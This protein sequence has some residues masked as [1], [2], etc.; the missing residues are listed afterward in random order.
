MTTP[1]KEQIS[2]ALREIKECHIYWCN[3]DMATPNSAN[4]KTI[5]TVLQSAL[6]NGGADHKFKL[7]DRVTKIKG[8]CW[9]GRVVGFYSTELTPIGYAVESETENGSVQIYPEKALKALTQPPTTEDGE[10][11]APK[12]EGGE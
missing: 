4:V 7:G 9:T 2:D 8:S 5:I 10:S 3:G 12:Y 11:A 1:T 6:D